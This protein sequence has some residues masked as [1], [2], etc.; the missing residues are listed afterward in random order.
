MPRPLSTASDATRAAVPS[1]VPRRTLS[2]APRRAHRRA[3]GALFA[4]LLL[5]GLAVPAQAGASTVTVNQPEPTVGETLTFTADLAAECPFQV[6]WKVDGVVQKVATFPT[7]PDSRQFKWAFS[8]AGPHTVD[9]SATDAG[10]AGAE[11]ASIQ[12]TV[13]PALVGTITATPDPA[14]PGRPVRLTA[15]QAGGNDTNTSYF[16]AWDTDDDGQ[17]DDSAADG[18]QRT[19]TPTY[20][21][22]GPRTVRV[23]IR[24][25]ADPVHETIVTR[26]LDVAEPAAPAPGAPPTPEPA[27]EPPCTTRLAFKL[28]EVT[29]TGCFT[30]VGAVPSARWETT[31]GVKLNGIPF[32]DFG[33]KFEVTFPDAEH[34]GGRFVTENAAIRLG[35]LNAFTGDVDFDLPDG[36]Q[37]EEKTVATLPVPSRASLFGLKVR[38]SI[39]LRFGWAD[40]GERYATL[41]L[42]I[43]LPSSFR[44]SPAR[45]AGTVTGTASLKVS[46]AGGIRYDGLK[47]QAKDVWIGRIKVVETC[48]SFIPSGGQSVDSCEAPDLD[49][50]PYITCETDTGTDR[51]DGN[52]VIQLP[53]ASN[54]KLAAFGGL[55]DGQVSKL[56]GFVDDL[57]TTVPIV[58]G[59]F[60]NRVGIGLCLAPP[61]FKLR[62]DVGVAALPTPAGPILGVNG[63][64]LYTDANGNDPWSLLVGGNVKVF[65][66]E[67]GSGDVTFNAWG[68][69]DFNLKAK[70][71]FKIASIEGT[72]NG[73]IE[74]RNDL[75]NVEGSLTGCITG[76]PCATARG[77]ISSSGVAGCLDLGTLVFYEP[78]NPRQGSFGFGSISFSTR[79][80][81]VPIKGGFGYTFATKKVDLLGGSCDFGPYK[82]TRGGAGTRA[83]GDVPAG[84]RAA[85]GDAASATTD[86][87]AVATDAASAD[88]AAATTRRAGTG[89]SE[90]ISKGTKAVTL[91]V[92]GSDGPP[93]IVLRGPGGATITS[94]AATGTAQAKG[95]YT[96]VEN[97]TDGTTSVVLI[98]PA[99]GVWTVEAAPGSTSTPTRLD[100]ADLEAPPVLL[101]QIRKSSRGQRVTLAYAVAPGTSVRLTERGP[102]IGRTIIGSV[103]G[104]PCRGTRPLPDGRRL[105]CV[106]RTFKPSRGPGG[107]RSVQAVVTR[108]GIAL[109]QE[110]VAT[111]VAPRER[112][113]ALPGRL[114]ARRTKSGALVVAFPKVEGASRYSA[115]AVLSD[116]RKLGFDLG[117]KCRAVRIPRVPKGVR[118]TVKVAG[119][120]YDTRPGRY[121]QVIMT[122]NS[123]TAGPFRKLPYP[124]R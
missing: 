38:G 17:F 39:A 87:A 13:D 20:P 40:D 34:P 19:V 60:L 94:P 70:L 102:K 88:P 112:L 7:A 114:R 1:S 105:R 109:T 52:A 113:P 28:T 27:P 78:V 8:T 101:G 83:A 118:A 124:C 5:L 100:R 45:E 86:P 48:F 46:Q 32:P 122:K 92:V 65:G 2:S 11:P 115:T 72:A 9:V 55:A 93:K 97:A 107:K 67:V 84:T 10:C 14:R 6:N 35:G 62:G 56:G 47:I 22:V 117:P 63:R 89:L 69:V 123:V 43:E 18:S 29:T 76:L 104:R 82:A 57:G 77:L 111:F 103:K 66:E 98:R 49:G 59:V 96:L 81:E 91:R 31:D 79:R 15:T 44:S 64:F 33:Q 110:T 36:E 16:Y 26:T 74:P 90:E 80:V 41:P 116:G 12:L 58:P 42:N 30:Q 85:T 37:G 68:D 21:T 108:K 53:T 75:F 95:R 3:I 50:S 120:R 51:W 24:D 73:W 106:T 121:R 25:T 23:R 99:A 61:P 54:T 71:D 4:L 119:V